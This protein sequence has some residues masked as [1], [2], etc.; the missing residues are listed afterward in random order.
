MSDQTRQAMVEAIE[1]HLRDTGMEGQEQLGD[2]LVV[3]VAVEIDADL[4]PTARYL[5]VFKEE[6]MLP[7]VVRGLLAKAE[8]VLI[9][10]EVKGD[11]D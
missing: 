4:H 1:A 7:H 3:A 5:T 2:V 11:E 9:D 6:T 10:S 8:D